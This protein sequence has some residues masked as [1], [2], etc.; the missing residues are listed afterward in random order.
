MST[1]NEINK[2]EIPQGNYCYTWVETPSKENGFRGKT[3]PCPYYT[4]KTFNGVEV[5]WCL[6]LKCGGL[7]NS[8]DDSEMDRLIEH[9]GNEEDLNKELPLSLLWDGVKECGINTKTEED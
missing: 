7:S 9:F 1:D 3:K 2:S 6:F 4:S 5:P 8:T